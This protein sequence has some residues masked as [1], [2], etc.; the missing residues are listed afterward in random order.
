MKNL[1]YVF[2]VF[3]TMCLV[4]GTILMV[5]GNHI[6]DFIVVIA[7]IGSILCL[8]VMDEASN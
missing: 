7:A 1:V 5:G 4:F 2:S 6:G 3:L 8:S